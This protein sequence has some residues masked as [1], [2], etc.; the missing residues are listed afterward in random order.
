MLSYSSLAALG[1]LPYT[2]QKSTSPLTL[3]TVRGSLRVPSSIV[4]CLSSQTWECLTEEEAIYCY[5]I[6]EV[7]LIIKDER[8]GLRK[9]L[10]LLNSWVI[11]IVC[12]VML[13]STACF[14][15]CTTSHAWGNNSSRTAVSWQVVLH[16]SRVHSNFKLGVIPT[17]YQCTVGDHC[18][19]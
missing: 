8:L 18:H 13:N 6:V 15:I 19:V 4:N 16:A 17:L 5:W 3:A 9:T 11:L 14:D 10:M 12:T 7:I 2:V 1:L